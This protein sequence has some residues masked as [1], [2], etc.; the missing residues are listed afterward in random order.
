MGMRDIAQAMGL[1]PVQLYRLKL[2]KTDILAE[3][4]IALNEEQIRALPALLPTLQ[5]DS[6][7]EKCCGYLLALYTSDIKNM[8]LRSIGAI[9]GWSWTGA[10]ES[11]VI[12]QVW[13]FLAPVAQWLTQ[14]GFDDVG[15]R[16]YGIWA[17]YY[18]GYRG[19][20][21]K[22]HSAEE[23]LAEVRPSLALLFDQG[24]RNVSGSNASNHPVTHSTA[25]VPA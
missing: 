3:L 24:K 14:D 5:G 17:L 16:C 9:H 22:G 8:P 4:V 18:V 13:K 15:A 25:N 21:T 1:Q 6:A 10:Y 11:T 20:V 19:A 2:S 12:D 7:F 23:C